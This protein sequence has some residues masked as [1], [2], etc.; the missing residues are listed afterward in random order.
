MEVQIIQMGDGICA[1]SDAVERTSVQRPLLYLG[2][3]SESV[4]DMI[5]FLSIL[6]VVVFGFFSYI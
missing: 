3:R 6:I 5:N 2:P 4:Y 1:T